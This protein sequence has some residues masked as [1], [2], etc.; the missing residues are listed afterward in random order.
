[1]SKTALSITNY[2]WLIPQTCNYLLVWEFNFS[3]EGS[4]QFI[5]GHTTNWKWC[6][7]RIQQPINFASVIHKLSDKYIL[8]NCFSCSL[9]TKCIKQTHNG[10]VCLCLHV[11]SPNL[12]NSF[13]LNLTWK[14][15]LQIIRQIHFSTY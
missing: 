11:S 14:S 2:G 3:S 15:T 6:S 4:M 9:C 1:M 13:Q 12:L 10:E 5:S 8:A 7:A